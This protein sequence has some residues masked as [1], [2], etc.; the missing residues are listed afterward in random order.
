MEVVSPDFAPRAN[1][2]AHVWMLA[3]S[4]GPVSAFSSYSW[5]RA[6]ASGR[7]VNAHTGPPGKIAA[8]QLDCVKGAATCKTA[9][10]E[11][12]IKA[13]GRCARGW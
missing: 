13:T 8:H 2:L 5:E 7:D 1:E 3:V 11:Q 4:P 9:G 10:R 6:F 12:A